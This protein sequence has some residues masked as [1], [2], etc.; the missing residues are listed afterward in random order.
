[1]GSAPYL[2]GDPLRSHALKRWFTALAVISTGLVLPIAT[3]PSAF[4]AT[5]LGTFQGLASIEVEDGAG[6]GWHF[7]VTKDS[8]VSYTNPLN[9]PADQSEANSLVTSA[10]TTCK[11]MWDADAGIALGAPD[12]LIFRYYV[13]GSNLTIASAYRWDDAFGVVAEGDYVSEG[14]TG[15]VYEEKN[16]GEIYLDYDNLLDADYNGP[17]GD[18]HTFDR[19]VDADAK[20]EAR[21]PCDFDNS[22]FLWDDTGDTLQWGTLEMYLELDGGDLDGATTRGGNA[23][24][25]TTKYAAGYLT[26]E[27]EMSTTFRTDDIPAIS[28]AQTDFTFGMPL[29]ARID[30]S[31]EPLQIA[32]YAGIDSSGACDTGTGLTTGCGLD[33]PAHDYGP[34]TLRGDGAIE[35]WVTTAGDT[36]LS[37]GH[38]DYL[39]GF[40]LT[41]EATLGLGRAE[42]F[43]GYVDQGLPQSLTDMD[44]VIE[45]DDSSGVATPD[46]LFTFNNSIDGQD[47]NVWNDCGTSGSGS[48]HGSGSGAG[49][50]AENANG[51]GNE[52]RLIRR[53]SLTTSIDE[54]SF[55]GD[56]PAWGHVDTGLMPVG[57]RAAGGD[58][59]SNDEL[60]A[61][62]DSLH[63]TVRHFAADWADVPSDSPNVVTFAKQGKLI[64]WSIK[65]ETSGTPGNNWSDAAADDAHIREIIADAQD[66]ATDW[67]LP[68]IVVG[69]HHEPH[70]QA[71]D[72]AGGSC[73]GP[74]YGSSTDYKAV[75]DSFRAAQVDYDNVNGGNQTADKVVLAY[76]GVAS[77][78]DN[79]SPVGASDILRPSAEDFDVFGTDPYNWFCFKPN[80]APCSSDDW[81]NPDDVDNVSPTPDGVYKSS[82][83]LATQ[84]DKPLFIAET[85]THG[86]CFASA[87]NDCPGGLTYGDGGDWVEALATW[88]TNDTQAQTY[89]IGV[90]YFH[91][92]HT[93]S[94][95]HDWRF[96]T[97]HEDG[98]PNQPIESG[99]TAPF[100]AMADEWS[101]VISGV[102]PSI[103]VDFDFDPT[104]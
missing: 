9:A 89:V 57:F 96:Y 29:Y 13:P 40:A 65:H 69:F 38:A 24:N 60:Q 77:H 27:V 37:S 39:S 6:K 46:G 2:K 34:V 42:A 22:P 49:F 36:S 68:K 15:H 12:R 85:A 102:F 45:F 56:M 72:W 63:G 10:A 48:C 55:N 101:S 53:A 19:P 95:G 84:Y 28:S 44:I 91:S 87:I 64:V 31:D 67:N 32:D 43:L 18:S 11:L 92:D 78:M 88:L 82:I 16:P 83:A 54:L 66:L 50:R 8:N 79:G 100:A 98:N 30:W 4:A 59:E 62:A 7:T 93:G 1:M 14:G 21:F 5:N 71:N 33:S 17:T 80:T 3:A 25:G 86:G 70:D 104:P 52:K 90:T 99:T 75:Y 61:T 58:A 74:C 26:S 81:E 51:S 41:D 76:I 103:G 94:G 20:G 35:V 23:A 47:V 73:T 97:V